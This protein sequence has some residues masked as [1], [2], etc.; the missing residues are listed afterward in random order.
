MPIKEIIQFSIVRILVF[1]CSE[2]LVV[3]HIVSVE[4]FVVDNIFYNFSRNIF[5]VENAVNF[6]CSNAIIRFVVN[7]IIC[8][9][10]FICPFYAFDAIKNTTYYTPG[11][12]KTEQAF[13]AY[14]KEIK[15]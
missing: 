8:T 9:V 14:W 3:G 4:K 13:A 5:G 15:K 7:T 10:W 1:L 2:R 12:N 11:D 6:Y